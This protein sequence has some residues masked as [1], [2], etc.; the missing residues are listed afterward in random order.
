MEFIPSAPTNVPLLALFV[1]SLFAF[2]GGVPLL[3]TSATY[4][5]TVTRRR[6]LGA[7]T[8]FVVVASLT[9]MA[10][11]WFGGDP[12]VG[13]R[14]KAVRES[15]DSYGLDLSKDERAALDYPRDRPK[16]DFQV[17]GSFTR[18]GPTASGFSRETVY[19]IWKD[20]LL[21][22]A[23]SADG[24]QFTTLDSAD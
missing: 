15:L 21:H 14:N 10:V 4:A 2:L 20:G 3:G 22:L 6:L 23:K 13:E 12:A 18:E 19:L 7:L 5:K 1:V 16:E 17:F 11:V 24:E 8:A 9:G